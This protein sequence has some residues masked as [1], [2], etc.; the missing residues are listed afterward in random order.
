MEIPE[1]YGMFTN[2]GNKSIEKKF[3]LLIKGLDEK[4]EYSDKIKEFEKF[5]KK[6]VRMF[7]TKNFGES[8]DTAVR[9]V[10]WGT[11]CN[12][13]KEYNINIETIDDI[14]KEYI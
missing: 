6:Y 9:E 7:E 1:N 8:F 13:C 4:E 5:I 10:V 12:I 14:W 11:L 2:Q 3:L